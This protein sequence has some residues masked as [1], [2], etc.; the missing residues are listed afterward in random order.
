V[1]RQVIKRIHRRISELG[2]SGIRDYEDYLKDRNEEWKTLD[3][4]CYITISRFY[5]DKKTFDLIGSEVLPLLANEALKNNQK[6]IRCCSCGCCSGEEPYTLQIIWKL[7]I[8]AEF[9]EKLHLNITAID[10]IK[11]LLER[12]EKGYYTESSI[13]LL[14]THMVEQAFDKIEGDFHIKNDFKTGIQFKQ[15]DIRNEMPEGTFDLILC[16]NLVFTY[17]E[18]D[19]QRDILDKMLKKLNHPG[20][21]IIGS[22][23]NLP[24][25]IE[26]LHTFKNCKNIYSKT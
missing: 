20:F 26:Q 13:K 14:S 24:D 3:S 7:N 16:R 17:F 5:R 21:L 6:E 25:S 12:A 11:Y 22:H 4:L 23:E 1:R 2:L 18:Y 15:Q 8:D 19:L 9:R 10:R